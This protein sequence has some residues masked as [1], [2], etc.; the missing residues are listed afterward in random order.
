MQWEIHVLGDAAWVH[1]VINAVSSITGYGTLGAIGAML[2]L[3][4]MTFS[5]ITSKGGP[6]LDVAWF[7]VA[8]VVFYAF[9]IPRAD[10]VLIT[11]VNPP[12]HLVQGR[13]YV[14]DNVPMGLAVVGT[15]VTKLGLALA[16]EYDTTF[17]SAE[18]TERVL[19]GAVGANIRRI[20]D[21]RMMQDLSFTDSS[22]DF[23]RNRKNMAYYMA[24][25]TVPG[26]AMGHKTYEQIMAGT[27][28][29][30]SSGGL[31]GLL[32]RIKYAH[33]VRRTEFFEPDGDMVV[34]NCAEAYERLEAQMLGPNGLGKGLAKALH[35]RGRGATPDE[36]Y[37]QLAA[38]FTKFGY[39]A[40]DLQTFAGANVMHSVYLSAVMGDSVNRHNQSMLVMV[41]QAMAQRNMQFAAEE[42][43]F[44]ALLRPS[45][46]FFE[47]LFYALAPIIAFLIPMGAMGMRLV[48]KYLMFTIWVVLYFPLLAIIGAFGDMQFA[49]AME[50]LKEVAL[51]PHGSMMVLKEAQDTMGTV[52]L[53]AAAVPQLALAI[54]MGGPVAMSA[55]AGRMQG[56]DMVDEK[57]ASPSA[58][59][60]GAF[61]A[62]GASYTG[63][64]GEGVVRS[65]SPLQTYQLQDSLSSTV[66]SSKS[67]QQQA[68]EQYS[69]TVQSTMARL[70]EAKQTDEYKQGG[71]Y[72]TA[73]DEAWNRG[74][75]VQDALARQQADQADRK[76]G[77]NSTFTGGFG[78]GGSEN[79]GKVSGATGTTDIQGGNQGKGTVLKRDETVT[80]QAAHTRALSEAYAKS[81]SA[82]AS[83]S[84][85]DSISA[86]DAE[87]V[88]Q[89]SADVYSKTL[90][91][92]EATTA[93][94]GLTSSLSF[95]DAQIADKVENGAAAL[96]YKSGEDALAAI[97][98]GLP[99]SAMEYFQNTKAE[100]EFRGD[101]KGDAGAAAL[102]RTVNDGRNHV[103]AAD[104]DELSVGAARMAQ[105]IAGQYAGMPTG[106]A[107]TNQGVADGVV[108]GAARDKVNENGPLTGP[109]IT[110]DDVANLAGA[111]AAGADRVL[112]QSGAVVDA[113]TA[114]VEGAPDNMLPASPEQHS[115]RVEH[116][117][118]LVG[119]HRDKSLEYAAETIAARNDA[120]AFLGDATARVVGAVEDV[121][122]RAADAAMNPGATLRG[123]D[124]V[125]QTEGEIAVANEQFQH[126][127]EEAKLMYAD[128]GWS[129]GEMA[130]Y[131]AH[132]TWKGG[133]KV[134]QEQ[135][136]VYNE[137]TGFLSS[138][139]NQTMMPDDHPEKEMRR[140]AVDIDIELPAEFLEKR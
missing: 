26:V 10:R 74:T 70:Q 32:S 79:G 85:T 119:D 13:V 48:G 125:A 53:L 96:G 90:A 95:N 46:S 117:Q 61:V 63:N 5:G 21:L 136:D 40:E 27:E 133:T 59:T 71:D 51:T 138:V 87:S 101:F 58:A 97:Q 1:F 128:K 16:Q 118:D 106:D 64:P 69:S 17:G 14:V 89:Q 37:N 78:L 108:H 111:A 76:A 47:A 39:D 18:D 110:R 124:V 77:T 130:A 93:A 116:A 94:S 120:S 33:P 44:V 66:S 38:T 4:A 115:T 67:E 52:S 41:E 137:N 105:L 131:A 126:H 91:Y 121:G 83:L 29:P 82:A 132:E 73:I 129:D 35:E 8:F 49:G 100:L 102:W 114:E 135:L 112:T 2:G 45:V 30:E 24:G 6:Q 23:G 127:L 28:P 55:L 11:E 20:A 98:Q 34:L 50:A 122:R 88:Q 103:P 113:R 7:A 3:L 109:N 9:F 56:G 43:M 104:R 36:A 22:G 139:T 86:Q 80:D 15:V 92:Q 68:S 65:G 62:Q 42:S 19:T 31:A 25:C 57:I 81:L 60:N 140:Q 84:G 54:L 75:A 72:K 134:T 123:E 99:P 107:T 12:S